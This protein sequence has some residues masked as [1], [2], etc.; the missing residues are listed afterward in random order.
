MI[1]AGENA[2]SATETCTAA[3]AGEAA[4]PTHVRTR[5]R[6][7]RSNER[8]ERTP[9]VD[10]APYYGWR[11]E[12]VHRLGSRP[13]AHR[14]VMV[15]GDGIGPEVA[16]AARHVLDA[17]DVDLEWIE[18]PAGASALEDSRVPPAGG[19]ARRDPRLPGRAE[20]PDH[21]A[22]RHGVPQRERRAPPGPRSVRGR[23]SR[24]LA[25]GGAHAPR[26]RRPRGRAGEHRGP[27]RGDRVRARER[28]GARAPG[29]AA[30]SGRLRG[31]RGRRHHAQAHQ[32]ERHASDRPVRVR[33]RAGEP[34]HEGHRGPQGQRDALLRRAVP[35]DGARGRAR[36]PR[37]RVGGDPGRPSLGAAGPATVGLRRAAAA[38]PLRRH[39]VATCAPG[40]SAGS[41]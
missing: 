23:P 21:D 18:R 25:P 22:G 10:D 20:G 35:G 41:A 5:R 7:R 27:L 15:A 13:M 11:P 19:D 6:R 34:P 2:N 14:V 17:T 37:R 26:R 31:P 38:E 3:C 33:V 30:R 39:P 9:S 1:V 4:R 32:R 8:T 28:G 36:V 24:P 40:S 12:P 16:A 29:A